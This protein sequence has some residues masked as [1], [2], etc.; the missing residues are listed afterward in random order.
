MCRLDNLRLYKKKKRHLLWIDFN[1]FFGLYTITA[2]CS[3]Q[4]SSCFNHFHFRKETSYCWNVLLQ[5][6]TVTREG[7]SRNSRLGCGR[8]RITIFTAFSSK[9]KNYFLWNSLLLLSMGKKLYDCFQLLA[10]HVILWCARPALGCQI[11]IW[12]YPTVWG[13]G[14]FPDYNTI[15]LQ[16]AAVP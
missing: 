8:R 7:S 15:L 1:I 14:W 2:I 6:I 5:R 3:H 16:L 12:P 13:S 10:S 11:R 4:I 9:D